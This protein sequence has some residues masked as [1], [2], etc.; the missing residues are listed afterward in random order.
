ML[1]LVR[2]PP[3]VGPL[4]A[5]GQ[6]GKSRNSTQLEFLIERQNEFRHAAMQAKARGNLDLA[7]KYLLESKVGA[8]FDRYSLF[9]LKFMLFKPLTVGD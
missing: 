6:P 9:C 7:K 5:S 8:V 4:A 2:P 1:D 3:A